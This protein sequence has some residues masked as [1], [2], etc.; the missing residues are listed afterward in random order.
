[1]TRIT[2]RLKRA[3]TDAD[4]KI[5]TEWAAGAK[6][7]IS[8]LEGQQVAL[9]KGG[10]ALKEFPTTTIVLDDEGRIGE[11]TEITPSDALWPEGTC[12]EISVDDVEDSLANLHGYAAITGTEFDLSTLEL[13]PFRVGVRAAEL[14]QPDVV[15]FP[16]PV[17][18]GRTRTPLSSRKAG[19]NYHGFFAV[20]INPPSVIGTCV[21]PDISRSNGAFGKAGGDFCVAAFTL[22]ISAVVGCASVKIETAQPGHRVLV[23][24]YNHMGERVCSAQINADK[25]VVATGELGREFALKPGEY[26]LGWAGSRDVKLCSVGENQGQFDLGNT[27][28]TLGVP[29]GTTELPEKI[30]LTRINP[31]HLFVPPLVYFKN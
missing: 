9:S 22:P 1:M 18:K 20:T 15:P 29:V 4:G 24:L 17:P 28:G 16:I 8:L 7:T 13:N 27:R 5:S 23:A 14:W 10:P 2:G 19:V 21:T 11:G 6:V 30:D 31:C 12:Y 3:E 26:F 25:S